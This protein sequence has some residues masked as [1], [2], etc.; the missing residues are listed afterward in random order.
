MLT[1]HP[2]GLLRVDVL[3]PRR[4]GRLPSQCRSCGHPSR[5]L[6]GG[7]LGCT[8]PVVFKRAASD[9]FGSSSTGVRATPRESARSMFSGATLRGS[10]SRR[11]RVHTPS[12]LQ[13]RVIFDRRAGSPPGSASRC[14]PRPRH[15]VVF[16]RAARVHGFLASSNA[17]PGVLLSRGSVNSAAGFRGWGA[18]FA[19]AASSNTFAKNSRDDGEHP[20]CTVSP[21]T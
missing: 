7:V 16:D 13:A 6:R 8:L 21:V 5:L 20:M 17:S 2:P 19:A 3:R 11:S 1:R 10:S 9:N 12:R 18:Y 14:C 15:L 4:P